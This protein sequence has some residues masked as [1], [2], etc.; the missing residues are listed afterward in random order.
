MAK[1]CPYPSIPEEGSLNDV[2]AEYMVR[3]EAALKDCNTDKKS[4]RLWQKA[5]QPQQ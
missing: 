3:M 1:D 2:L 4:I 5:P